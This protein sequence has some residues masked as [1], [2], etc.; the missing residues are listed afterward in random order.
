MG[1]RR[2]ALSDDDRRAC[3]EAATARLMALPELADMAGRT[4]AGYVAVRGEI[5]PARALLEVAA[6]GGGLALPRLGAEP[7]R[8]RFCGTTVGTSLA[9]GPFGLSEPDPSAQEIPPERIDMMIVPGLAFDGQGR[10]LGFGGGYYDE[11]L[12]ALPVGARRPALIGLA[13]DFQIVESCPA[14][15]GDVPVDLVVT[16][17][18]VVRREAA[19]R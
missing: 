6:R 1:A 10:R 13:Y 3:A 11:A 16:E 5:D 7:P 2:Q 17:A 12:G 8:M 18:R 15:P 19:A 9:A 14:G 4:V